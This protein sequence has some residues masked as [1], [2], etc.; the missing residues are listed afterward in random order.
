MGSPV[1]FAMILVVAGGVASAQ[2]ERE[3]TSGR[4]S[5]RD[6]AQTKPEAPRRPSEWVELADPSPTKHGTVFV[7]VGKDAGYFG[8]LRVDAAKGKVIVRRVKVLF[9]DGKTKQ[10]RPE[11][12]L[13]A[14]RK[15][16]LLLDLGEAKAIERV[17]VTTDPDVKGQYAIYGSVS[18]GTVAGR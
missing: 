5:Y 1:R 15:K 3:E 18:G 14:R 16:S 8:K 9:E 6:D 12:W 17:V 7:V 13:D 2:P 4:V 10:F 11:K